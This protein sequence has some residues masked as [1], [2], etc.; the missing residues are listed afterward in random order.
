[1]ID[2][3]LGVSIKNLAFLEPIGNGMIGEL[4]VG[5]KMMRLRGPVVCRQLALP[6]GVRLTAKVTSK[7]VAAPAKVGHPLGLRRFVMTFLLFLHAGDQLGDT[8]T[9]VGH[10]R[11][12]EFL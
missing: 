12:L 4:E 3:V 1:M 9:Q 11:F 10:S 5:Y 8:L 7:S 2:V 6:R